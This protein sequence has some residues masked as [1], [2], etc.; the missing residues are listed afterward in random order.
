MGHPIL[1]DWVWIMWAIRG[2]GGRPKKP[3]RDPNQNNLIFVA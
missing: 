3:W 2:K 1:E